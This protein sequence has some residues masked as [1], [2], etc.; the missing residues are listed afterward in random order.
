L[1]GFLQSRWGLWGVGFN[2]IVFLALPSL[3]YVPIAR[4]SLKKTL[5]FSIPSLRDVLL[6]LLLTA[7][8][9]AP[10]ELWIHYQEKIWPL[11]Q[12]V[13]VFYKK[14][15]VHQTWAEGLFK[16]FAL[17][18]IPAICEELFFR[19]LLYSLFFPS[20]GTLKTVL[21]T[22]LLFAVAH[23]NPWYF[24][25]YFL[26]G[27]FLGWCRSWKDNLSLCVLAHLSNNIYSLY[28]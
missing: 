22:S 1:G 2:E 13:E 11:P 24:A 28:G 15:L 20:F 9:I 8:V 12:N 14:L 16:L 4:L 23:A 10:I 3:I 17:A 27:L 26:L 25:Y 18:L 21:L 6:V 5:P 19:G 7:L